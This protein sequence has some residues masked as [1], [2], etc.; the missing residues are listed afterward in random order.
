MKIIKTALFQGAALLQI[1]EYPTFKAINPF[2]LENGANSRSAFIINTDTAVYIKY[3]Q[4][5][6]KAFGEHLFGFTELNFTELNELKKRF[7]SRVFVVLVC[8]KAN[9]ICVLTLDE[10]QEHVMRRKSAKG[11]NEPQYQIL[12]TVPANSAFRV[13]VNDPGKKKKAL[14]EQKVPRNRFPRVIFETND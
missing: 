12:V 7:K 3:A 11:A 4:K 2:V 5:T 6:T 9:E 13:F 10:L 8:M 14:K 1:A